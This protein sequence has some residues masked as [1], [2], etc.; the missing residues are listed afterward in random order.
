MKRLSL[1]AKKHKRSGCSRGG[2]LGLSAQIFSCL[3]MSSK[4]VKVTA[5]AG[6][7][8]SRLVTQPR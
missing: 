7:V 6:V 3:L 8:R 2:A 5:A 1:G 4:E